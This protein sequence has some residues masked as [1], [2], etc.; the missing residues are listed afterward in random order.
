LDLAASGAVVVTNKFANKKSLSMYS[1]NILMCEPDPVL[2]EESIRMAVERVAHPERV[3]AGIQGQSFGQSWA[4][5]FMPL[6]EKYS[7]V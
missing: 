5:A 1:D 7:R 3:R 6:M 2:I 4:E